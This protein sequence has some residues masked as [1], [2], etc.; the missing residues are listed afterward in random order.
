MRIDSSFNGILGIIGAGG[1]G[2]EVLCCLG[3]ILGWKGIEDRAVF[4]VEEGYPMPPAVHGIEVMPLEQGLAM[5]TCFLIAIGDAAARA[6]IRSL[7]PSNSVFA[8]L[9][10][11]EVRLTPFTYIG[12]GSIVLSCTFLSVDVQLGSFSL[13]NP[14]STIS[15]DCRIGDFFTGSPGINISG[16]VQIGRHVFIGTNATIRNAIQI[17]DH[18]VIGMGAVVTKDLHQAGTYIG[19]PA[20]LV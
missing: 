8:T 13:V 18:V 12:E 7:L 16:H 9:I 11:P 17:T 20:S 2:K 1:L 5:C 14:G 19:N 3:D 6:R 15:H 4:L 10:H